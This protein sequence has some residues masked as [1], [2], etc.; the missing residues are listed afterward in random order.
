[1]VEELPP[2]LRP[3][4]LDATAHRFRARLAGEDPATDREFAAA[5]AQLRE[6]ELPFH[7]A[8]VQLEHGES[9]TAQGRRDDAEPLLAEARETFERLQAPPWL[10]RLDA[11]STEDRT[12]IRA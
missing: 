10:D 9:L 4:F 7:L 6:L 3:P 5:A 12:A 2:G 8:V 11:Q 1:I